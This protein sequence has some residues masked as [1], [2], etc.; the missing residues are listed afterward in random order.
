MIPDDAVFDPEPS[1]ARSCQFFF[2]KEKA[3]FTH[4]K[5]RPL[6]VSY[7]DRHAAS[8]EYHR[9]Y[10]RDRYDRIEGWKVLLLQSDV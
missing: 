10:S 1:S 3:K 8:D 6:A 4:P 2:L 9:S 5:E 7:Y